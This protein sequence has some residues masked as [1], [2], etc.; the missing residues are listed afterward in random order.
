MGGRGHSLINYDDDLDAS[1]VVIKET[2]PNSSYKNNGST[3]LTYSGDKLT[4][5]TVTF[6]G[7]AYIQT[8]SYDGD[9]L[10]GITVWSE[11]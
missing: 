11:E 3:I 8:L 10:T 5:V 9:N 6:G 7:V 1:P 2:P 4:Q